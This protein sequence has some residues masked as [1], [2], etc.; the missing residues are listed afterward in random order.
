MSILSDFMTEVSDLQVKAKELQSQLFEAQNKYY[1][2]KRETEQIII[3]LDNLALQ[4]EKAK[5]GPIRGAF[6]NAIDKVTKK[7]KD[8]RELIND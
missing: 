6:W 8:L 7:V 5:L 3:D 1:E 2:L 4:C